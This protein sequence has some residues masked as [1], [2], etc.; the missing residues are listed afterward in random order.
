M[1]LRLT[2]PG[3]LDFE[4]A[5]GNGGPQPPEPHEEREAE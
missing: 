3:M 1:H 5:A 2:V 4:Y